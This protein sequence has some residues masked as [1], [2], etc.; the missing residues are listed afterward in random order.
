MTAM[1]RGSVAEQKNYVIVGAKQIQPWI[2]RTP[3][4]RLIRGASEALRVCTSKAQIESE[5]SSLLAAWNVRI[6]P[7]GSAVDGVVVATVPDADD[8]APLASLLVR[9]LTSQLPGLPW[10]AWW[11]PADDL[12]SAVTRQK[13]DPHTAVAAHIQDIPFA[14]A[15]TA[16]RQEPARHRERIVD[17]SEWVGDDCRRRLEHSARQEP[18]ESGDEAAEVAE[19]QEKPRWA[20]DFEE[21]ARK[22]GRP[23]VTKDQD[24]R[25]GSAVIGRHRS[26]NHL[27]TIAGDGNRMG[28]LFDALARGGAAYAE[29][30]DEASRLLNHVLSEVVRNVIYS[31]STG[32]P[33]LVG[34]PHY[35]GGDDLL[36]SIRAEAAWPY[37]DQV[38][39]GFARLP[40]ELMEKLDRLVP[41]PSSPAAS[42]R[43]DAAVKR[44]AVVRAINGI[45]LGVGVVFSH[46]STPFDE[47]QRAAHAALSAAKKASQ[48]EESSVCWLD[49]TEGSAASQHRNLTAEALSTLLRAPVTGVAALPPSA[50]SQL[51]QILTATEP[52]DRNTVVATWWK[53][54]KAN[55]KT[56]DGVTLECVEEL[57]AAL[58]RARWWPDPDRA[59]V[60]PDKADAAPDA[61]EVTP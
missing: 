5:L 29:L 47:C 35:V 46:S 54:T 24:A 21:L 45:S 50:R 14:A 37:V 17:K 53:R 2:A 34:I 41:E 43:D 16:C 13:E 19:A 39:Q 56:M 11:G 60:T 61:S 30:R 1:P 28:D 20:I 10:E 59:A 9:H 33:V 18:R 40:E 42:G 23:Q 4:L 26:A 44:A 32:A 15:C 36:V 7:V 27:A 8:C 49:M 25:T 22:G 6:D 51:G 31:L 52:G 48:G 58:S 12:V 3:R 57:P 38:F 55:H